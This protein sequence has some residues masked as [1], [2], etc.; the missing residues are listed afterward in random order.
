MAKS[1]K[2]IVADKETPVWIIE[3]VKRL[4]N[5]DPMRAAFLEAMHDIRVRRS[6]TTPGSSRTTT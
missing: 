4:R 1:V 6:L 3:A 2:Q 5:V